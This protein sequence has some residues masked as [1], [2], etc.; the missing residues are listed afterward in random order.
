MK[1]YEWLFDLAAQTVFS[2]T[3]TMLGLG[4]VLTMVGAI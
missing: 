3:A 1:R 4:A 2:V